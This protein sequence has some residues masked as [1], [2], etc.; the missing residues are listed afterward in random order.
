M[1]KWFDGEPII[2]KTMLSVLL[3]FTCAAHEQSPR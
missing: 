1:K 2:S 3:L